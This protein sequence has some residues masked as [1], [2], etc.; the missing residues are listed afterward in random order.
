MI[1]RDFYEFHTIQ[2]F[3]QTRT[4]F[5][6]QYAHGELSG[7]SGG[8]GLSGAGSGRD[9]VGTLWGFW[10]AFGVWVGLGTGEGSKSLWD[11]L[12]GFWEGLRSE[13]YAGREWWS[14]GRSGRGCRALWW[15]LGAW[16]GLGL[17][18]CLGTLW[19]LSGELWRGRG[20]VVWS[21]SKGLQTSGAGCDSLGLCTQG[22]APK[23]DN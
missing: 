16:A 18:G 1:A 10:W 8:L 5:L 15:T 6:V 21:G 13:D 7:G 11:A 9:S 2:R 20:L 23:L 14:V 3:I 17:S 22:C 4:C 12:R 19:G